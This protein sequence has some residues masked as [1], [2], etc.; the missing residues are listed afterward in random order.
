MAEAE[1]RTVI[2]ELLVS[3]GWSVQDY[4]NEDFGAS[5]GVAVREFQLKNSKNS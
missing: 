2:D 1:A 4:R 5:L 3:A